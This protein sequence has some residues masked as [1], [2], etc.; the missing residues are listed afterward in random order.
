[1]KGRRLK[2]AHK[3][4][5]LFKMT[6]GFRAPYHIALDGDFISALLHYKIDCIEQMRKL[7]GGNVQ[8]FVTPCIVRS[9]KHRADSSELLKICKQFGM[10][11]CSHPD[12]YTSRRCLMALTEDRGR[13][14]ALAVQNHDDLTIPGVPLLHMNMNVIVFE[15]PSKRSIEFSQM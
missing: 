7:F 4:L 9:L 11:H 1:M 8:L 2:R 5:L 13:R 10:H 14:F 3:A 6:F 15:P 12:T